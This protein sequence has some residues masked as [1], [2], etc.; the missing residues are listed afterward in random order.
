MWGSENRVQVEVNEPTDIPKAFAACWNRRDARGIANLFTEDAEFVNVVGIWW[1]HQEDIFK[2]HDYGLKVIFPSSHLNVTK[3]KEKKITS[4]ISLIH[5]RMHLKGQSKHDTS[6][7][8]PEDRY[9]LFSFVILKQ[10]DG[11]WKAISAHNTDIVPGAE[12]NVVR[13][14]QIKPTDYRS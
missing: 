11:S 14:G 12:T 2:A 3:V 4:E 1:H 13:G 10:R 9:T 8:A 7:E 6:N 5:A